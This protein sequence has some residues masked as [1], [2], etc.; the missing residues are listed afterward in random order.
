VLHRGRNLGRRRRA[1]RHSTVARP[2]SFANATRFHEG[3]VIG[4]KPNEIPTSLERDEEVLT[5]SYSPNRANDGV[6][7]GSLTVSL[8]HI[9][10]IDSAD[11]LDEALC[12]SR[13]EKKVQIFIRS[14]SNAVKAA[15]G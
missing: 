2:P 13:R 11:M 7:G 1:A 3:V 5:L 6:G 10:V 15:M 4:L 8:Q 9:N 12:S 14:N